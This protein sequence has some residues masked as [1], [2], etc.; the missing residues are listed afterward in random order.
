MKSRMIIPLLLLTLGI[1]GCVSTYTEA[2]SVTRT[3]EM[4]V[5]SKEKDI[6][7]LQFGDILINNDSDLSTCFTTDYC[8]AELQDWFPKYNREETYV[9][10]PDLLLTPRPTFEEV[11]EHF[12]VECLRSNP[13][14]PMVYYSV[15]RVKEGGYY[16]VFWGNIPNP[17]A[18]D[19]YTPPSV[20]TGADVFYSVYIRERHKLE[21]FSTI[22][23]GKSTAADVAEIDPSLEL[24]FAR[25]AGPYSCSLLEDGRAL[26]FYYPWY[27]SWGEWTSRQDMVVSDRELANPLNTSF[28]LAGIL[29]KDLP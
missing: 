7:F 23:I 15:Y 2:T 20:V 3:S 13:M 21:D 8:L 28:Y 12:P 25:N 16:Y 5:V 22:T 9:L 29:E 1:C 10:H 6:G 14:A 17:Y 4:T 24:R 27:K 11:N 19:D 26:L 18:H